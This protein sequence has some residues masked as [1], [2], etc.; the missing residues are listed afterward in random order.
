LFS[1]PVLEA[2]KDR[3][4]YKNLFCRQ[5]KILPT[6]KF[7]RLADN[8]FFIKEKSLAKDSGL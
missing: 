8:T 3:I 7:N 2:Q 1:L 6:F 4:L 5:K